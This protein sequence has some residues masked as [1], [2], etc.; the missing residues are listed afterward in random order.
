MWDGQTFLQ[1]AVDLARRVSDDVIV[2]TAWS[3]HD[4]EQSLVPDT[5]ELHDPEPFPGP[6]VAL[7]TGLVHVRHDI[8]LVLAADMP[9]LSAR[10]L[11]LMLETAAADDSFNA[12]ALAR[13]GHAQPLPLLVRAR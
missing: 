9:A 3:R 12:V 11:T 6:L 4:S 1:K 2:L 7:T 10:V 8:C 5:R 13:D